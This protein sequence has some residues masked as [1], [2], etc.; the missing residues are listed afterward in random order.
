MINGTQPKYGVEV[1]SDSG[2][3]LMGHA[4][5]A[6]GGGSAGYGGIGL[7]QWVEVSWRIGDFIQRFD[8]DAKSVWTGGTVVARHRIEV[9]S[10]IP[11]DVVRYASAERGRAI[12]LMF[13]ILDDDVVM[14][15]CVQE[16]SKLGGGWLFSHFGGDFKPANWV[17][18]IV[19]E[20]GWYLDRRTG[21]R[22]ETNTGH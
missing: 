21:Q 6:G 13:R 17:Q 11:E 4:S 3:H 2:R 16:P 1:Q 12:K 19:T 18:G 8:P 5:L 15:W 20:K 22:V 14:G 7:P 10:R 9:A